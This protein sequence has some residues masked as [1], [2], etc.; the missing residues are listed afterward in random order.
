MVHVSVVSLTEHLREKD[1]R[2]CWKNLTIIVALFGVLF[3]IPSHLGAVQN[4]S[5]GGADLSTALT[6]LR[7]YD[8]AGGTGYDALAEGDSCFV[9][10]YDISLRNFRVYIYDASLTDADDG[11]TYIRPATYGAAGVWVKMGAD[12]ATMNESPANDPGFKFDELT[13]TDWWNTLDDT[14]NSF[15]W[16]T[17]ATVG[18]SV[19]MELD[20]DGDLHLT[21][22]LFCVGI[23]ATG[24]TSLTGPVTIGDGGDI[25]SITE[26]LSTANTTYSG[27][28][29][30]YT[31]DA[32]IS[33]HSYGQAVHIDTDMELVAADADAATTAPAIGL[34]VDHAAGANQRVLMHGIMTIASWD[35]TTVG[36]YIYLGTAPATKGGL[37]E[38]APSGTGDQVQIIGV[39]M[40]TDTIYVNPQ[41]I[42]IEI[43]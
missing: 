21:G 40:A 18:N 29:Q 13:G 3:I 36:G 38:T 14:G 24:T 1:M 32:S 35:W 27:T 10:N 9:F 8:V 11:D 28:V 26:Y 19:Q 4:L 6:A 15:E 12:V 22:G 33:D 16:R 39:V 37:T 30:Y 5:A 25:I 41:L 7:A 34:L 20:E 17:N 43:K 23:T 31:V 42:L 2:K